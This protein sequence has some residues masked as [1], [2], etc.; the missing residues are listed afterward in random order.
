M[1]HT[2]AVQANRTPLSPPPFSLLSRPPEC[3]QMTRQ[4]MPPSGRDV[5][6]LRQTHT[7]FRTGPG[8]CEGLVLLQLLSVSCA[9][10]FGQVFVLGL[11]CANVRGRRTHLRLRSTQSWGCPARRAALTCVGGAG[12]PLCPAPVRHGT[13]RWGGNCALRA[14]CGHQASFIRGWGGF[15]D[16]E[17]PTYARPSHPPRPPPPLINI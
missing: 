4:Q 14:Y 2:Y 16:F 7:R 11:L 3:Q 8:S 9:V 5:N 15:G 13:R 6:A 1:A 10:L 17:A 12:L